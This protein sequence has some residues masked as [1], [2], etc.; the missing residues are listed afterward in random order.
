MSN[1]EH[2]IE[3]GLVAMVDCDGW[4]DWYARMKDDTNWRVISGLSEED[5]WTICQYV[6]YSWCPMRCEDCQDN[7]EDINDVSEEPEEPDDTYTTIYIP[8]DQ[9]LEW[10][11]LWD[12]AKRNK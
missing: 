1:L 7:N 8:Q 2:L 11:L 10:R 12:N 4:N 9:S 6:I 3:N 5:L